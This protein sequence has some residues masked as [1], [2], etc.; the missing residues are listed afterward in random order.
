MSSTQMLYLCSYISKA[1]GTSL[2][3]S[4]LGLDHSYLNR[5]VTVLVAVNVLHHFTIMEIILDCPRVTVKA[6]SL[7]YQGDCLTVYQN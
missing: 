7:C 3:R 5:E 4:L 2:L 6:R 1:S